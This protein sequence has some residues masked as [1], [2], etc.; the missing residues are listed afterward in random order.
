MLL[1]AR[2]LAVICHLAIVSGLPRI[3]LPE[4]SLR[5]GLRGTGRYPNQ[6]QDEHSGCHAVILPKMAHNF[7]KFIAS[8]INRLRAKSFMA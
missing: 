2:N 6:E 7:N 5:F 8:V 1:F 4:H 3:N